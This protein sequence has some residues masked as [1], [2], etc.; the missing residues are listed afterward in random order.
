MNCIK[1]G[2]EVPEDQVFCDSC[3]EMM[4]KYPVKPGT[5]VQLPQR[6]D[7][8]AAKKAAG[9][10]RPPNTPEEQILRL[11]KRVRR[12]FLL[13]LFTLLLLAATVYPAVEYFLGKSFH[14]PGQN[15]STITETR[16]Q[17]TQSQVFP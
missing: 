16:P 11:K 2:R 3:R 9:R 13:W 10:R 17:T 8:P 1:C 15:Y 6:K 7:S 14:L 12:V 5:A 4:Q